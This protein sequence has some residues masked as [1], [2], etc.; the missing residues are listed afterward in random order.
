MEASSPFVNSNNFN[1]WFAGSKVVDKNGNPLPVF[2]GSMSDF[3]EFKIGKSRSFNRLGF[4]FDVDP[5]TPN[6]FALGYNH[7]DERQV[8]LYKPKGSVIVAYL[9]IKKPFPVM[10][11]P[12]VWQGDKDKLAKFASAKDYGSFNDH[13]KNMDRADAF[14]RLLRMIPNPNNYKFWDHQYE[15]CVEN[16]KQDLISEGY[17]GIVLEDTYADAG[18]RGGK[19]TN[20]W[21]AFYPNQVKSVTGNSGG[22]DPNNNNITK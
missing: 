12:V 21:I 17:D 15:Q 18:T 5:N 3:A 10:S 4:W 9:S 1:Q 22:F 2:H 11:E 14:D 6:H 20:W 7:D 13:V 8:S 16:F 19:L